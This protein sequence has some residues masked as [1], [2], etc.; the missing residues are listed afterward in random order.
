MR[1]IPS[2]NDLARGEIINGLV[3]HAT[4]LSRRKFLHVA[5]GAATFPALSRNAGAQAYPTRPVRIVVGFPAG[6][7]PDIVARLVA[8]FLS[9]RLGQQFVVDNRPGAGGNIGTEVVVKAPSDGHTLLFVTTANTI[10]ASLYD[11]LNFDFARDIAPIGTIARTS[12]VMV[13][14]PTVPA[15]TLPE[16]VAYAKAN[17]GK[18]NMASQGN[19]SMNHVAGELFKT[20]SGTDMLHVPYR[21]NPMPDLLGGQVQVF[22]SPISTAIGN[23][24]AGT[25]RPLAVTTKARLEALPEVPTIAEFV[26]GYE[27]SAWNGI[28]S[29]TNTPPE[30]IE[31]INRE[32]IAGLSDLKIKARIADI[33][34]VPLPTATAE[35]RQLIADEI[36]KWGRVVKLAG[37]KP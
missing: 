6:A 23:I 12:F 18:I 9:E 5:A 20:M 17:P 16:F 32:I 4:K 25:L 28:G 37:I 29:P 15:K 1:E 21:G 13:V 27:A 2:R 31:K 36:Q 26:P 7:G 24:R 30:I 33:G 14:N 34:S 8:Q 10:N 11:R 35:F 22:F 19:G 3:D